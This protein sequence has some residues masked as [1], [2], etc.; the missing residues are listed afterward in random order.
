LVGEEQRGRGGLRDR[1]KGRR[2]G[3]GTVGRG[4]AWEASAEDGG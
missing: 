1:V 3:E 4:D 2:R